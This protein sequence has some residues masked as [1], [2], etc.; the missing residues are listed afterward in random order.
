M[1]CESRFHYQT[2][3]K[4]YQVLTKIFKN[5]S[6]QLVSSLSL[7]FQRE[8][9]LLLFDAIIESFQLPCLS[10]WDRFIYVFLQYPSCNST[11][12]N[13]LTHIDFPSWQPKYWHLRQL[14]ALVLCNLCKCKISLEESTRIKLR[15]LLLILQRLQ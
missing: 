12:Q 4:S 6:V 3:S 2:N 5:F 15:L 7:F 11:L 1:R 14:L 13:Q 8:G 9:K 10:N